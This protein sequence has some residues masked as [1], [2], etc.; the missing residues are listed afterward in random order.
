M[1]SLIFTLAFL[2]VI[3]CSVNAQNSIPFAKT[4]EDLTSYH[5][6]FP[7]EKIYLHLD[8]P[9][10]S[11]G[12]QIWFKAYLTIGNFNQLSSLSKILYVELINPDNEIAISL[13]LPVVSGL[14]FG[15]FNLP[16]TLGEGNYRI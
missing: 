5:S 16:D 7:R 6:N 3:N 9:Y 13:R 11:V 4:I 2:F 10:Y 1:K 8:K 14:T 15:D 12:E